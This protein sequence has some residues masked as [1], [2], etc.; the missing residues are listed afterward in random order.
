T[1][2]PTRCPWRRS[3]PRSAR[4]SAPVRTSCAA[5]SAPAGG[6]SPHPVT[7]RT[8]AESAIIPTRRAVARPEGR[9]WLKSDPKVAW[10]LRRPESDDFMLGKEVVRFDLS[11]F[12][13]IRSVHDVLPLAVGE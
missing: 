2:N 7:K 13:G 8:A 4:I 10:G 1:I 3:N 9:R 6:T 11:I 5:V 12:H